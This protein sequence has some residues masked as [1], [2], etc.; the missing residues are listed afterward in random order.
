MGKEVIGEWEKH[1][2]E[3]LH[4]FYSSSNIIRVIKLEGKCMLHTLKR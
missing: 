1:N 4:D 2:S 3:E